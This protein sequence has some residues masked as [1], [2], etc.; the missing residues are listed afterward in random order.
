[1]RATKTSF[2]THSFHSMRLPLRGCADSTPAAPDL[3][4][5]DR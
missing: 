5:F 3:S 4:R 2:T 1:M